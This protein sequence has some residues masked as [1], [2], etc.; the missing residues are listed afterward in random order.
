MFSNFSLEVRDGT[1]L[2]I[3]GPNGAGK[4][5][6]LKLIAGIL[7]PTRGMLLVEGA[8]SPLLNIRLG[9]ESE[10]TGRENIWLVRCL[11]GAHAWRN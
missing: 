5:T 8:V 2:A 7:P 6:L 10:L 9:M 4:T 1:R 11:H 3:V